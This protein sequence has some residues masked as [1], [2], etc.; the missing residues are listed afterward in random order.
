MAYKYRCH[1]IARGVLPVGQWCRVASRL[2]GLATVDDC[3]P[4]F[5][6]LRGMHKISAENSQGN[7]AS[8]DRNHV[9]TDTDICDGLGGAGGADENGTRS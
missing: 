1:K 2:R 7:F 8:N 9:T 6:R 4:V 5:M 3:E